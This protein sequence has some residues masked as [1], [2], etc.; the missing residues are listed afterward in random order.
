MYAS[1]ACALLINLAVRLATRRFRFESTAGA[2]S[3]IAVSVTLGEGIPV[4]CDVATTSPVR[5]SKQELNHESAGASLRPTAVKTKSHV[6]SLLAVLLLLTAHGPG[7]HVAL[8]SSCIFSW[9]CSDARVLR[10]SC[11]MLQ[12]NTSLP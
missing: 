7:D 3:C 12:E 2:G 11:N 8:V 6:S 4:V 5:A 10:A 9:I 1:C